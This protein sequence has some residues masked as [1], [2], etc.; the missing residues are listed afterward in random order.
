M[1]NTKKAFT[2]V[3]LIV[4][5]TILAVLGTIAFIS[6]QGYSGEARDSK[7]LSDVNN[8]SK[9]VST[10]LARGTTLANLFDTPGSGE[11]KTIDGNTGTGQ[12]TNANF[13][14]LKIDGADFRD[15]SSNVDYPAAYAI[16]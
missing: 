10:E 9:A 15:D 1:R 6:L 16:G 2:L 7:R 8:L 12:Q 3:E 14:A 13:T 5:I 11:V 4:V